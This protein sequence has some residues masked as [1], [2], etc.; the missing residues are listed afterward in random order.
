MQL[1]HH[2]IQGIRFDTEL[3][4]TVIPN[5]RR[6]SFIPLPIKAVDDKGSD[7]GLMSL[8]QAV[9]ILCLQRFTDVA[10][11][12]LT[13][14]TTHPDKWPHQSKA[15]VAGQQLYAKHLQNDDNN[16]ICSVIMSATDQGQVCLIRITADTQSFWCLVIGVERYVSSSRA[17]ALLLL[18]SQEYEPWCTGHNARLEFGK[19]FCIYRVLTGG[20]KEVQISKVCIFSRASS[21]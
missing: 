6:H 12:L 7:G 3:Q 15:R 17:K 2:Y 8:A 21:A 1:I 4:Y 10:K 13:N 20:Y 14:E 5:S 16:C 19:K 18:D 9:T 11:S